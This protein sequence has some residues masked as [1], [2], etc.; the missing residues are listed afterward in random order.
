MQQSIYRVLAWAM[1]SG[2][3]RGE[4]LACS[5]LRPGESRP[6]RRMVEV[7]MMLVLAEAARAAA[8]AVAEPG[9]TPAHTRTS[10][11][12]CRYPSCNSRG[13]AQTSLRPSMPAS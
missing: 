12:G 6:R 1:G 3:V 4:C 10:V 7:V 13:T 2:R 9:C 11:R 8:A 5:M